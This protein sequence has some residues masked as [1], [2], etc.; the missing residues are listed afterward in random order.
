MFPHLLRIHTHTHT[1]THT[2]KFYVDN[3]LTGKIEMVDTNLKVNNRFYAINSILLLFTII[4]T[5][6]MFF[7]EIKYL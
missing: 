4:I 3:L 1:H 7:N 5:I 6:L 2:Q